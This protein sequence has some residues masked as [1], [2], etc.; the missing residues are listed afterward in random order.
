M[1]KLLIRIVC[2][3]CLLCTLLPA[4][5]QAL[6]KI[7]IDMDLINRL[8]NKDKFRFW[9]SE[10]YEAYAQWERVSGG[11]NFRIKMQNDFPDE[12]VDAYTF[13]ISAKN[14][15]EEPVLLKSSDGDY[16]TVLHFTGEKKFAS[17][18]NGYTEYFRLRSSEKI[19]YVDVTL[20]KYH[21]NTGT[22]YVDESQQKQFHWK[23]D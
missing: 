20:I 23:I 16:S 21:T 7:N 14:V 13:E 11:V 4:C 22:V 6:A 15:Y 3:C 2:L 5:A 1:K 19:R 17:G 8:T 10:K 12:T 18:K 9:S